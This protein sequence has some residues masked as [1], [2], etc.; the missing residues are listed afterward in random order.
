[1]DFNQYEPIRRR[2]ARQRKMKTKP[3]PF[4]TA[5]T[6]KV[7][8]SGSWYGSGGMVKCNV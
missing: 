3:W 4:K 2:V 1:M 6:E 7:P 5:G 8:A